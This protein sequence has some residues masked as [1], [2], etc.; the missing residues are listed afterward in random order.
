M[1]PVLNISTPKWKTKYEVE[2]PNLTYTGQVLKDHIGHK[3]MA[4]VF[5]DREGVLMIDHLKQCKT[6][7]G[8]Y[9][10]VLVHRLIEA[11]KE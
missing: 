6:L 4:S 10:A 9:Y 8:V 1:R 5:W 3:I 7:T 11:I 2:A